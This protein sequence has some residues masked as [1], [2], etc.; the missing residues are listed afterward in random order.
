MRL[1]RFYIPTR[2]ANS[3][4]SGAPCDYF[5]RED[6]TKA[7]GDASQIVEFCQGRIPGSGEDTQGPAAGG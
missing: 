7:I 5:G 2:Y 4:D 3:F 6:A 1:D